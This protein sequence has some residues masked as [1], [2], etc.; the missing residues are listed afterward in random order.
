MLSRVIAKTSGV[1]L[2]HSVDHHVLTMS[3]SL[4][5]AASTLDNVITHVLYYTTLFELLNEHTLLTV[6]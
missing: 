6:S 5:I 4:T 2:S 3:L 1:F